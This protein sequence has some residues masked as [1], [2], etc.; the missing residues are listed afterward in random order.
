MHDHTSQAHSGEI[1]AGLCLPPGAVLCTRPPGVRGSLRGLQP[2]VARDGPA[3]LRRPNSYSYASLS[4]SL[5][6]PDPLALCTASGLLQAAEAL[7]RLRLAPLTLVSKYASPSYKCARAAKAQRSDSCTRLETPNA[8]ATALAMCPPARRMCPPAQRCHN[9]ATDTSPIPPLLPNP[10][11]QVLSICP[12]H[13]HR[14]VHAAAHA[15]AAHRGGGSG[16]GGVGKG[17]SAACA[18]SPLISL[19][20]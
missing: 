13:D 7:P 16:A 9:A 17:G 1:G 3:L 12:R 20:C 4:L 10:A 14:P 18:A 2:V 11:L 15:A 19:F 6:F 8:P 5:S